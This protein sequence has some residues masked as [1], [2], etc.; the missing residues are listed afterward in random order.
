MEEKGNNTYTE[1]LARRL[2]EAR[3]S[4]G[5]SV[6]QLA[7][8]IGVQRQT[9]NYVESNKEGRSLTV[10]NLIKVADILEV[11]LDYLLGRVEGKSDI[12]NNYDIK[13]WDNNTL[14]SFDKFMD[15]IKS[16]NVSN[17]L[18]P[19]IFV[20]YVNNNILKEILDKISIK[21]KSKTA[22]NKAEISKIKFLL[23]YVEYVC[24]YKGEYYKYLDFLVYQHWANRY[25]III[26]ECE[27]L[28]SYSNGKEVNIE[29]DNITR[30]QEMLK[31]FEEYL[32]HKIDRGLN[33]SIQDMMIKIVK[34][35][36]YFY[37][38][39]RYFNE[40]HDNR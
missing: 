1:I 12:S 4:K 6:E 2:T 21:V 31:E 28:V 24:Y 10:A 22:L 20:T 13:E 23:E 26:K 39:Q 3:M 33:N 8:T 29:F 17:D 32:L 11:S 9:L 34:D 35:N 18:N 37:N 27:N 38:I 7:D 14:G 25:D 40:V 5:M 19:Y 15:E 16:Q 36:R 30:F